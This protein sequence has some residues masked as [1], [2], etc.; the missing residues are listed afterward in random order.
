MKH[1]SVATGAGEESWVD[2]KNSVGKTISE[3]G[4]EM[5]Y[6]LEENYRS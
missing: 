4:A 1:Y 6:L 2:V 5:G 3:L